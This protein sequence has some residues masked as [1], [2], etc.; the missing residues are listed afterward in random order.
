MKRFYSLL[1]ASALTALTAM[2]QVTLP[3]S[4]GSFTD[5]PGSAVNKNSWTQ[6]DAGGSS[7]WVQTTRFKYNSMNPVNLNA[8]GNYGSNDDW[9]MTPAFTVKAGNSYKISFAVKTQTVA[10]GVTTSVYYLEQNRIDSE[11]TAAEEAARQDVGDLTTTYTE[12]S[13]TFKA[14]KAGDNYFAIRLQGPNK[15]V[16]VADVK[17]EEIAGT[18]TPE[19]PDPQPGGDHDVC[20]GVPT[21]YASTIAVA[22]GTF[23]TG[24]TYNNANNDSETW[25]AM[26]E[27]T[28][29]VSSASQ[30]PS[31]LAARYKYDNKNEAD[32]YL[33]SPA[34]HLDGGKEYVVMY[35]TRTN[36][37]SYQERLALYASTA[38]EPDA[39][40]A[41]TKLDNHE[42]GWT[43]FEK[44]V[45]S[46]TPTATGDYYFAFHCTSQ[47][48]AYYVFVSDFKVM[49]NV[50]APESVTNLTAIPGADRALSCALSWVLPTK[51]V[52]GVDFTAEQT[53]E[54]VEIFRD[55]G[56]IP[57]ATLNEAATSFEDTAATGLT[58]GKHTYSVVVTVAGAKSAPVSVDTKYVGPVAPA[59]IPCEFTCTSEDD[60]GL[61]TVVDGPD[62]NRNPGW[63]F[64]KNSNSLHHATG[65][66]TGYKADEWIMSLPF[67]VT[68]PGYYRVTISAKLN[69][70]GIPFY[71]EGAVGT[72]PTIE[73]M[74]V[75]RN[76]FKFTSDFAD[77]YYDFYASEAG[78]YY[79]GLHV[80]NMNPTTSNHFYVQSIKVAESVYVPGVVRNLR[81][82]PAAD[83]SLKVNVA[84]TNPMT[85]FAGNANDAIDYSA[86][87]YVNDVLLRTLGASEMTEQMSIEIPVENAG[88]YT[89]GVRTVASDGATAPAYPTV[90]SAWVGPKVV[91]LPY[92]CNFGDKN[93]ATVGIWEVM[94]GNDDGKTWTLGASSYKLQL[95]DDKDE[96][97]TPVLYNYNDVLLSPQF[98]MQPGHYRFSHKPLGGTSSAKFYYTVALV[99]VGEYTPANKKYVAS[100]DISV[101]STDHAVQEFVM[102]VADAGRYQMAIIVNT[103]QT[104]SSDYYQLQI[105]DPSMVFV[106]VLPGLATELAV[107]PGENYALEATLSW[108]NP[109]GTNVDDET[110]ADGDI[111]KAVVY[112]NDAKIAEIT[113]GLVPGE[114]ALYTDAEVPAAGFHNYKVEI[115]NVN[116]CSE[117]EALTV[118]SPWIGAGL[119]IPEDEVGLAFGED[120]KGTATS[121]PIDRNEFT[122]W[123]FYNDSSYGKNWEINSTYGRLQITSYSNVPDAWAVSPKIQF[124]EN[125]IYE[126]EV[127]SMYNGRPD[128]QIV[129]PE[130]YYGQNDNRKEYVKVGEWTISEDALFG[131]KQ[132]DKYRVLGVNSTELIAL[133]DESEGDNT[134]E[135]PAA[136]AI[137]V[138]AGPLN[139]AVH[140]KDKGSYYV[141]WVDIRKVGELPTSPTGIDCITGEGAVGFED[142]AIRF[143]GM[144]AV[145]IY[146]LT[147]AIVVAEPKARDGFNLDRLAGG[148][149]IVRVTPASGAT[150]TMKIAK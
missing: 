48:G 6:Y 14:D 136:G 18:T 93:D 25:T 13:F 87:V 31:K 112:R 126:I 40:K 137:K 52:F 125:K 97:D 108:K 76:D 64:D 11:P 139:L 71:L 54:K 90:T 96:E 41:S 19:E 46:F 29:S 42:G 82:V 133:A 102:N 50:F 94:D 132:V 24:W 149:Y 147:G 8:D 120:V 9:L 128:G 86:E 56:E 53:V 95:S 116:G 100:R 49:E 119:A 73:A 7:S 134:D 99:K 143:S 61:F 1:T 79:A 78:T 106:P 32:D 118:K 28:T 91:D 55:G 92:S 127:G 3:Y 75:K 150:T 72:A 144:A 26:D 101:N 140:S 4:S 2:A 23:D 138:P 12:K 80:Y 109:T 10:E 142:G 85:S 34:V 44:C 37:N 38:A 148:V 89:V 39:I 98:D 131:I 70:P 113:E 103:P 110:L 121:D 33:I 30:S 67:A 111:V 36:S 60:F 68:K 145:E 88:R 57:I 22:A 135:D 146:D 69:Y 81:A 122:S 21:P 105:S 62:K 43:T 5:S 141:C 58:S 83:E 47:K 115:Y 59:A 129:T 63:S 45:K 66:T 114:T 16:F 74:Q 84:W 124:E 123:T 104:I 65:S 130:L 107:T 27:S 17:I 117:Q 15:P 51:S 35:G 77:Y 20:N